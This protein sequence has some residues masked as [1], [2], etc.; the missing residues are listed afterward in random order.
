MK[1][2][3]SNIASELAGLLITFVLSAIIH[4][5]VLLVNPTFNI[6]LRDKSGDSNDRFLIVELRKQ[7]SGVRSQGSVINNKQSVTVGKQS[8]AG[9][10][11]GKAKNKRSEDT[12][13]RE[14]IAK[15]AKA[16][17]KQPLKEVKVVVPQESSHPI[18]EKT[19]N[20]TSI[21]HSKIRGDENPHP[22]LNPLPSLEGR[23]SEQTLLSGDHEES[24]PKQT[25]TE[26]AN[27]DPVQPVTGEPKRVAEAANDTE[28]AE[29]VLASSNITEV[30]SPDSNKE[31]EEV[32]DREEERPV[33]HVDTNVADVV[34]I[35]KEALNKVE[36]TS[37]RNEIEATREDVAHGEIDS[38]KEPSPVNETASSTKGDENLSHP[39]LFP[40]PEGEEKL[41][42]LQG[43]GWG[44][45]GLFSGQTLL[46]G[47][48]EEPSSSQTSTEVA[49]VGP[50]QQVTGEPETVAEGANDTGGAETLLVSSNATEVQP[51]PGSV[52]KELEEVKDREEEGPVAHVDTN[53]V[54]IR[55]EALN[56]TEDTS[57]RN[58]IEAKKDEIVETGAAD[59]KREDVAH[60]EIDSS[61]EEP[62][63]A[64]GQKAEAPP[65]KRPRSLPFHKILE[66]EKEAMIGVPMG[67]PVVKITTPSKKK[68]S[69]RVQAIG[70]RVAGNG[71]GRVVLS[72]NG[73]ILTVPLQS[74]LFQ[75]D[76][77][78][79][80]GGNVVTA[81]VWDGEGYSAKD[82]IVVDVLP[83]RNRFALFVDEPVSGEIESDVA[84]VKGS[85]ADS[86][87]ETVKV[88]VNGEFS[89]AAVEEGRFEKTVLFKERENAL[90]VEA[91]NQAGLVARSG[92]VNVLVKDPT[93]SDI[94][95]HLLWDDMDVE[96]KISI[97]RKERSELSIEKAAGRGIGI[98]N[99]LSATEGRGEKLFG[100]EDA[101]DGGY[102]VRISADKGIDCIL[103]LTVNATDADR[104]KVRVFEKR[105]TEG[106][107]WLVGRFLVPEW[108]FWDE[109]EWFSGRIE[110]K[111]S[112]TKYKSPEG[113]TWKELKE[114]P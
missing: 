18:P 23:S 27:V 1:S 57:A 44:G 87:V 31:L 67:R 36:D 15:P 108:V 22:P 75:W 7:G 112:I 101:S 88:I 3:I 50:V 12:A 94:Q 8:M 5:S 104:R 79:K 49:Q 71:I 14:N 42:P 73:E 70:G 10:Q 33:A 59:E 61:N 110:D 25:S 114:G 4:T 72:I 98:V 55:E 19:A 11:K 64:A 51:S 26:V 80:E 91:V 99:L 45:D 62:A 90:E 35:R 37:A 16:R 81:T 21:A 63:T 24:S 109:D 113:V 97:I 47:D 84:I 20:E 39:H 32:K 66:P 77:V 107:E 6:S 60:G 85:V 29:T 54:D 74:G 30:Q 106:E 65:K 95:F 9:S 76:A 48:H 58:E 82:Q 2:G 56:K 103:T 96:P 68:I 52:N 89:D 102:T 83:E 41:P 17:Y 92:V 34:D 105:L 46:S 38:T 111:D 69:S 40:L 78:L 13:K 53:V 93:A 100:V 43:E 86:T 28:G